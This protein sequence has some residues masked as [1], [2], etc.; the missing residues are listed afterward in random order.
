MTTLRN[1]LIACACSMII[2]SGSGC[3]VW[4]KTFSPKYG[5]PANGKSFGA[6][7]ILSGEKPPKTK[8][9]RV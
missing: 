1:I 5:C 8:K 4:R 3:K 9:F 7:R 6:E 2:V